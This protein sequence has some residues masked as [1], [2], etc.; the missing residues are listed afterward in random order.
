MIISILKLGFFLIQVIGIN[1]SRLVPGYYVN[2]WF[3][4]L[5]DWFFTVWGQS[6]CYITSSYNMY[7]LFL[8]SYE[9]IW[10]LRMKFGVYGLRSC[11]SCAFGKK[12]IYV[13]RM[14]RRSRVSAVTY[15]KWKTEL[16]AISAAPRQIRML[17]R[18]G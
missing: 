12:I 4:G 5:E 11:F 13:D 18:C 6:N 14:D 3:C 9:S 16:S 10:L 15:Y 7:F 1:V 17:H 8:S 2:V